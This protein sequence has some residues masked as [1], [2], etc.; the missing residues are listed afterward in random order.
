M[1]AVLPALAALLFVAGCRRGADEEFAVVPVR[2]APALEAT[3]ASGEVFQ[4]SGLRGKVVLLSFGYR[5]CPDV[6]PTTLSQLSSLHKRLKS[7]AQEVEVVFVTVDPER[8]GAQELEGYVHTFNPRFT[9]L[10]LQGEALTQVLTAY[11]VT[12][13]RRYPEAA[14]YSNHTFTGELPYSVDHTGGYF[15]IDRHGA[16]RLRI[17]Y[18]AALDRLQ[19]SV[20]RLLAEE[21]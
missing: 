5:S 12:A 14:R 6:C 3:R 2:P 18:D 7:H 17:P 19:A 11:G 21:S 8:D 4:L 1:R 20:E 15:I 9:A 16:L 10:R 13:E